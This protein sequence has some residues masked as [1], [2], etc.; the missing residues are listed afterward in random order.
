M[1]YSTPEQFK[2]QCGYD[3]N[4]F[5]YPR[6]TKII[7]VK[8]K[9]ALYRYYASATSFAAAEAQTKKSAEEGTLVHETVQDILLGKQRDIDESIA[10]AVNSC[11]EFI[12]RNNIQ[13]DPQS[14]EKRIMNLDHSYAGTIDAMALIGGKF[15]VMDIKTSMDFYRDYNL[16]TAAY[17]DA[18]TKDPSVVDPQ[19]RWILRVDQ[20]KTC[21]K[22]KSTLRPKGGREKIR[23]PYPS[24]RGLKVCPED[25]HEW[26]PLTG[27]TAIKEDPYWKEDFEAFLAA[28]KLWEWDNEYWLKKIGYLK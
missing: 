19:T 8:S 20:I 21:P 17:M 5:W 10:P 4:G 9:P 2:E 18:L 11:I 28:K 13:V 22:C 12:D 24:I 14:I 16:Q 23:K 7:G 27:V 26:G 3:I 6:V 25:Q 1:Y 15:G